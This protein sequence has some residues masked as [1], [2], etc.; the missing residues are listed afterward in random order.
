MKYCLS[1]M[2]LLAVNLLAV[3]QTFQP[4]LHNLKL[5][6]VTGRNVSATTENG[7]KVI[8]FSEAESDGYMLLKDY[9]FSNGTIEFDVKGRNVPQQSFVGAAFHATED[10]K[11]EVIY[12]RPF[13]F[14]NPDTVRRPR[15]VQYVF[16]PDYPWDKL[17]ADS[18]GKYESKVNPVPNPDDWFHVKITVQGKLIRVYVN[19]SAK[20]SLEV[21]SLNENRTGRIGFWAGVTSNGSFANLKITPAM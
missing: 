9:K 4:D 15:S 7:K 19:N 11:Y 6:D 14:M 21:E 8:Q 13:N 2:L 5:W 12:F 18:P 16:M 3:A 17:R 1:F 20:P 10:K